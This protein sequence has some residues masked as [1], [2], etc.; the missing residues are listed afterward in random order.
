M[1][2]TLRGLL[3]KI[4]RIQ[5]ELEELRILVLKMIADSLPEEEVDEETLRALE[6]DL[7]DMIDG[8]VEVISGDEFIKMLSKKQSYCQ[9][10]FV[11]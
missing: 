1:E 8:R 5:E 4:D 11:I 9:S 6:R 3:K 10:Y 2:E 7:R